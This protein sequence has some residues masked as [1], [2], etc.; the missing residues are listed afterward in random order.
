MAERT[1]QPIEAVQMLSSIYS[2]DRILIGDGV[3][4]DARS[5]YFEFVVPASFCDGEAHY[6]GLFSTDS[7]GRLVFNADP[8]LSVG[9]FKK[10]V[11][12]QVTQGH[13]LFGV[14]AKAKSE[15]L[16]QSAGE[17]QR[18]AAFSLTSL[19]FAG[20]V[21]PSKNLL[22]EFENEVGGAVDAALIDDEGKRVVDVKGLR[23]S[24]VDLGENYW[25]EHNLLETAA[26]SLIPFILDDI[27][28]N[29]GLYLGVGGAYFYHPVRAEDKLQ[30]FVQ[31][32]AA[33]SS[34]H[35]HGN[36]VIARDNQL[37]A[38][39]EDIHLQRVRRAIF[40]RS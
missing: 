34:A 17:G 16:A 11:G 31:D 8:R 9:H 32:I 6:D 5:A 28:K 2:P 22:V 21:S 35:A 20:M 4:T 13:M 24:A 29:A 25:A 1:G 33:R 23:L 18:M 38:Q 3:K 37:V 7:E 36:V 27:D 14:L 10:E 30:V 19:E 12:L 39:F 40:A 26:Q 15:Q